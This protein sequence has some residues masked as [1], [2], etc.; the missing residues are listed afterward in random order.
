MATPER[1]ERLVASAM[2]CLGFFVLS[3]GLEAWVASISPWAGLAT[4]ALIAIVL[5]PWHRQLSGD[6]WRP[7]PT[8]T[9]PRQNPAR[10]CHCRHS[11]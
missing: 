2:E 10:G 7:Q 3:E 9:A 11:C 1:F 4:A 6:A 8:T 5:A